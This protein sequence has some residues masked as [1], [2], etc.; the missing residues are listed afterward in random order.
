MLGQQEQLQAAVGRAE[1]QSSAA[2]GKRCRGDFTSKLCALGSSVIFFHASFI[3]EL[4]RCVV[5][6]NEEDDLGLSSVVTCMEC[7]SIFCLFMGTFFS[8]AP[9]RLCKSRRHEEGD[10]PCAPQSESTE[11]T[12]PGTQAAAD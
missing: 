4:A 3:W 11:K 5:R 7:N 8:A 2:R 1:P 12:E 6:R 10:Q 9:Q